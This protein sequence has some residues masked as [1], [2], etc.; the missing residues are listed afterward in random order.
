MPPKKGAMRPRITN[1]EQ[2]RGLGHYSVD[3]LKSKE[4][5]G[6]FE[7]LFQAALSDKQKFLAGK[8]GVKHANERL[9]DCGKALRA[10]VTHGISKLKANTSRAVIDH[11]TDTLPD[12]D[13]DF[14]QPL[15]RDYMQTLGLLLDCP[16]HVES[17]ALSN[18]AG[19][20]ACVDFLLSR[21]SHLLGGTRSTA[22]ETALL[23]NESPAPGTGRHSSLVN[24]SRRSQ[25]ASQRGSAH[26][27]P[28][29]LSSPVQCL[30]S[31]VSA[32][33]APGMTRR[34]EV[35]DAV[36]DV[37]RLR[38]NSSKLH[39]VAFA[40]LNCILLQTAGDDPALGR[41]IT[42]EAVPLLSYCWQPRAIDNDELLF[43][44]RDEMLKTI[45]GIHLY[46]DSLLQE[47][48]SARLLGD[49]EDL[50]DVL[51]TEYSQR[52]QQSRLRLEDLTFSSA[53][54]PS[55]H[56]STGLFALRPFTQDAERR[57]VVVETMSCLEHIFLRH[58]GAGARCP[59]VE[60]EQPRKRQRLAGGS[61][62]LQ[63]RLLSSEVAVKLTALQI[64]PFYLPNSE[65]S[66][67][68]AAAI[69]D[70]LTP[71]ISDKQ[72]V[73]SSWA[74]IAC[75]SCAIKPHGNQGIAEAKWKQLWQ[76]AVRSLSIS[77]TCRAAC[78]LLH[79]ILESQ[80]LPH[81]AIADDV[82]NFVIMADICGPAVLVDSSLVLMHCVANLRNEMAPSA[83][84]KTY[85][86]VIRWVFST[87]KPADSTYASSYGA[88]MVPIDL[89]NLLLSCC[90]LSPM[91]LVGE[92]QLVGGHM[93]KYL[94]HLDGEDSLG[95]I[96]RRSYFHNT[97]GE[98]ITDEFT[99]SSSHNFRTLALE[100]LIPK[101]DDFAQL[102]RPT[103]QSSVRHGSEISARLS[104]ERLRS[105]LA[106]LV[107]STILLS[108]LQDQDSRIVADIKTTLDELWD[109]CIE[110]VLEMPENKEAFEV[111]LLSVAPYLPRLDTVQVEQF[112]NRYPHLLRLCER[113]W[114]LTRAHNT[115]QTPGQQ[116]DIMDVDEEFKSQVN[117]SDPSSGVATLPR[118]KIALRMSKHAFLE[119][120][121]MKLHL[122]SEYSKD[123]AQ[124]GLIT[125]AV[126]DAFLSLTDEKFLF[127]GGFLHEL[128][129]FNL[130]NTSNYARDIIEQVGGILRENLFSSCEAVLC[131]CADIL[132]YFAPLWSMGGSDSDLIS[133]SVDL[134]N[135]L[136]KTAWP[137]RILSIEA[138][139]SLTELLYRL[140]EINSEFWRDKRA[141]M[142]LVGRMR[143]KF[144]IGQRLT[145][146]FDLY[147]VKLHE[148][149]FGDVLKQLPNDGGFL[150]GIAFRVFVLAKLGCE[151][152]TLL[153]RCVYHILEI[154]RKVPGVSKYATHGMKAI[155]LARSLKTPQELLY[156]FAPQ[157]LYTLLEEGSIE[158]IPYEI[159]DF[160][161]LDSLLA[162]V[163]T[164]AAAIMIMR[165]QD[166]ALERLAARLG[167]A[168]ETIVQEGFSK[169]MAY[170]T[171][172]D[173][174]KRESDI[175]AESRIRKTLGKDSFY[176]SL[177]QNFVDIVGHFFLT[178]QEDLIETSWAKDEAFVHAANTM[179]EIK[180]FSHSP[181]QLPPDQQP[182]FKGKHLV[183]QLAHLASYTQ[184]NILSL[185]TPPLVTSVARRLLNTIHPAL[186]PHHALSVIR[187]IR[188]LVCL[189]G[190][191][192]LVSYPLEMLLRSIRPF[193][194]DTECADDALG[195]S[196][197]L[198]ANG[199]THMVQT[200]SFLAGYA[201]S[202]LAS[203]RMFLESSQASSTQESQFK[204]TMSKAQRF[205]TWFVKL[206]REYESP[207]FK[208]ETQAQAFKAITVSASNI[209]TSGNSQK[210]THESRLLLEILKDAEQEDQLLNNSA[211]DLALK[212]LCGDFT[213]PRSNQNDIL[214]SD[215]DAR[216]HGPMVWKSCR[217][218]N[219]SKEYLTW[220]GRVV[221]KSFAAS[222]DIPQDV[223]K[224]SLLSTYQRTTTKGGDSIHGLLRL[225]ADLAMSDNSRHAGLAESAVRRI[226]SFAVA[227]DDHD[228]IADCR[229]SLP[230]TLFSSSAWSLYQTPPTDHGATGHDQHDVFG[231]DK[232]ESP[233]WARHLSVHLA[234]AL[235]DNT[236]LASLSSV[237]HELDGF[238]EQSLPY[239]VHLVLV[240]EFDSQKMVK[241]SLSAA[242]KEWLRSDS[243]DATANIKLLVNV[244]IY[245]RSRTFP[246]ETSVIDRSRW[247]DVDST[248]AAEAAVRCGMSKIAL[249]FAELA[250]ADPSR[251]SRRS[252]A[253]REGEDPS[254]LLLNI[255]ES[256]DDP[257]A[258]Y[259]LER[260]A[261]LS[262][263]L[264]RLE[265]E[266]EGAKSLA[267]RGAQYDSHIRMRDPDSGRDGQCLVQ[268]LS[269][270]GLAG[271]SESLLQAHQDHDDFTSS[272]DTTFHTA[273]RLE[274]WNLPAPATLE[275]NVAISYRAYQS[276][277]KAVEL[278]PAVTAVRDALAST[279][280]NVITKGLK[281]SDLRQHLSTLAA[282]TEL[283]NV[284]GVAD[285]GDLNRILDN[286]E[287]RST[288]MLSGRYDDV[289]QILS[290][291]QT[292]LS[293]F[294]Q[295]DTLRTSK[296]TSLEARL[297]E[298]RSMLLSSS[299]Y[300]FQ[301][302]RQE[303]LSISTT[304]RDLVAPSQAIGLSIDAAV[305]M[306]EA[307][308]LWDYG[309][310]ISSIRLL[311]GLHENAA[312]LRKQN[313]PVSHAEVL[314]KVGHQ[315]SVAKLETVDSIQK[316][317]LEPSL[318][319]L[320]GANT[321]KEVG[322]VF[323]QFAT[324][325]DEQLQDPEMREDLTR[326]QRL[327]QNRVEEVTHYT[328]ECSRAGN[329][330]V[331]VRY[332]KYL[333]NTRKYLKLDQD[334]LERAQKTRN[335]FVKLSLENFLQ[336]LAASDDHDGNAL[337]F[338]ALWL[339]RS[340]NEFANR[341]V[342]TYLKN[343]PTRK[344]APLMNQLSSRLQ[345][346]NSSFQALLM[347]LVYR[348][349]CDHP[350]HGMYQIWVGSNSRP[351]KQDEVAI[352]RKE[353]AKKI[354]TQLLQTSNGTSDICRAIDRV[355][356]CYH[357]LASDRGPKA[358][359]GARINVKDSKE[360]N[361]LSLCFGRYKVPPPTIDI[362]LSPT[363]N[364][365][366][367]PVMTKLD[368]TMVVA[369]GVSAPK[370]ITVVASNGQKYKQLVKGSNDDLRQDAIM[371][372][373][374]AAVSSLL[375]QHRSTRQR[376][377]GIRT[378]KVLPLTSTTGII[379]FV[380]NTQPLHDWLIPAH[381]RYYPKGLK[382]SQCRKE[383]DQVHEQTASIRLSVYRKVAEKF[384]PV[385]R[386]FFLESFPDP[387]DW[388]AK[389]LAYT[390]STA[391][392]SILGHVLGLGDRHG[393]NILL[394]KKTGEV[395]HIDLGVAFEAGRILPIPEVVPFRMTRDIVDGMG[396]TKTDGVFR[397]CCEFTLD[398]LREETYSIMTILD[399]LRY[400]P[401]HSWSSTPVRLAKLQRA[402]R[403]GEDDEEGNDGGAIASELGAA[404]RKKVVNEPSEADRAL[405][406]VRK[407]LSKTLSVTATV[408]DLI[409]QATDE[410]N[411]AMLFC[412]WAAYA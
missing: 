215:A 184:F 64:F 16:A 173:I 294:S 266:K 195:I 6:L 48:S 211:R 76:L 293:L 378:Y 222:G 369:G 383:I 81:H 18:G 323:H 397:R 245:L 91:E 161:T 157:L 213:I 264:A 322:Q 295:K 358:K 283:D 25:A 106:C 254:E 394:D 226:V 129:E 70:H 45:H 208:S 306:D 53:P 60:D 363:K 371:E 236:V 55:G 88:H 136:V 87:W 332:Q 111:I 212:M 284:L 120:T 179:A 168:P 325:C 381:S 80:L 17:L 316:K 296:I 189:A 376:N 225:L 344:F 182:S 210:D 312:S 356:G 178:T 176:S 372:Q 28:G 337:R 268:T 58:S 15:A 14:F 86:H 209:R 385:M 412:G 314:S 143:V 97:N 206:L 132:M 169:I 403:R 205:H 364:Y 238:A 288:W 127:C 348:I 2:L 100:L 333:E 93:T 138:Q 145:E 224:E 94:L 355:S 116:S 275:N 190:P 10:T 99:S 299:I 257:D 203:L 153:R 29:D 219:S 141:K 269:G 62:R 121:Q 303:A 198:I 405:A 30:L 328:N 79:V 32:S 346:D 221:G 196:Q 105:L 292:T 52:S 354:A 84:Q 156:L 255:F 78:V 250:L 320:K 148:A 54:I 21:I 108:C 350:Y 104:I 98:E 230:E 43:S 241:R 302:A 3:S 327:V 167:T 107:S 149:I 310:M 411:L 248:V 38:L 319:A 406:V 166:A 160:A 158:D 4:Y 19:W 368:S 69:M 253:A 243:A 90:G 280:R 265:Y 71:M 340:E 317:Y 5:H 174:A 228:L 272:L 135:F 72:S 360:A 123:H 220:A 82:S 277:H 357:S 338:T 131:L 34:R 237:L 361:H 194:S 281:P 395:V 252:S 362:E 11:I 170:S 115:R 49:L 273:R 117:K 313:V 207:A 240:G 109:R 400:D 130:G 392:I 193:I 407:K 247:L 229:R 286:F 349:C 191:Q 36:L 291:R 318:K 159:F 24:L 133:P 249:M 282:L 155:A 74:M 235:Q 134:Y 92:A 366:N 259:G 261:S 187:K 290:H 140:M 297:V 33:N 122:F 101:L 67:E 42:R 343:V 260:T 399:V 227:T 125:E 50:L 305:R 201:L 46:L 118:Q 276:I 307:H 186:G 185:W 177:N 365:A 315:V 374:F 331:R 353:A 246:G 192:V 341:A 1:V 63:K 233:L 382:M 171:C 180:K 146:F 309:E 113:L 57:W 279:M 244:V 256:I 163:R 61:Y 200:P 390:R 152:P 124:V 75:A 150:E 336:S 65:V 398:A 199:Y 258:Y 26:L 377:L 334:E 342:N 289:S 188:I 119:A 324:F 380:A 234:E 388:Y 335:E 13:G 216:I 85:S 231:L 218:V 162:H 298:V 102:F 408:N 35:S 352:R 301:Q 401:L 56:F 39:R 96:L 345:L 73:L 147:A 379:E 114:D 23:D 95:P 271:L 51:W 391:A 41:A 404:D 326:L 373:V 223:L 112:C 204:A 77:S 402:A 375:R 330:Q 154:P 151:L 278:G 181:T 164:E 393:H 83:M 263:V 172:F 103:S 142:L 7:A 31:L 12:R 386:Y 20:E 367:V 262:N 37:L 9:D 8:S 300:R 68:Q 59:D 126:M 339:E 47:A 329:S 251:I 387:D 175:T 144:H 165:D 347:S 89:V 359:S 308:S 197:W 22:S 27:Q 409:N 274:K 44:V 321:G 285:A 66:G 137:N 214:E 370:I 40:T 242:A 396:V 267:F 351:N 202:T 304:L 239:L 410:K 270:L 183:V 232:I 311:Q 389:R 110:M 217:S 384:P 139:M 287:T 128:L